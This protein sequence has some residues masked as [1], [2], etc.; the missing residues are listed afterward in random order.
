MWTY[1]A[2]TG[3]TEDGVGAT[4]VRSGGG[5]GRL[6][7]R[8]VGWLFVW[9]GATILLYLVWLLW[10]TGIGTAD[11]QR[12][13]LDE[14]QGFEQAEGDDPLVVGGDEQAEAEGTD[15]DAGVP[16][17]SAVALLEF[18]RPGESR[19]PVRQE[20]LVVVEGTDV[21]T[22]TNGP[23]HY[24]FTAAPGEEGNFAV[25]GHRTTY[26]QPFYDMDQLV[27]GDLVHVTTRD[28]TRHTYEVLD[29][30]SGGGD[31]GQHII[32][33]NE[34]WVLGADPVGTGGAV[35]TLT[36]CHPRFS[37]TYRMIVFAQLVESVPA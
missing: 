22:L 24:P 33:P 2:P 15:G 20:P 25:A 19:R 27:P 14:F 8:G 29:G 17:G 36:T 7:L 23:G 5:L 34:T 35:L 6:A 1:A 37:A 9:L 16:T 4:Q 31:P 12:E 10:F 21:A 18:E 32:T 13:L 26:G 28:G 30:T 11:A 3:T